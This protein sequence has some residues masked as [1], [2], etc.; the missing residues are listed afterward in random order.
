MS[1]SLWSVSWEEGP[2]FPG[3]CSLSMW[4]LKSV[5]DSSTSAWPVV[6]RFA[7]PTTVG[8]LASP[9]THPSCPSPLSV[10]LWMSFNL[11]YLLELGRSIPVHFQSCLAWIPWAAGRM[12]ELTLWVRRRRW[13]IKKDLSAAVREHVK[14]IDLIKWPNEQCHLC[15]GCGAAV[16]RAQ[17]SPKGQ[18]RT[19][20]LDSWRDQ[21][22]PL[23]LAYPKTE[24]VSFTLL[25]K[26]SS[27]PLFWMFTDN[28]PPPPPTLL[29]T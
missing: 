29:P 12:T 6:H 18:Q 16:S 10:L 13:E 14:M 17:L 28:I 2:H 15:Y 21:Q 9:C 4:V 3:R 19:E 22:Y 1:P 5:R 26:N 25:F 20:R 27:P 7:I 11:T 23:P 24:E 8:P